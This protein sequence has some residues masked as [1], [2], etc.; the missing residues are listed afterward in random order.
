MAEHVEISYD[1]LTNIKSKFGQLAQNVE[2]MRSKLASQSDSLQGGN[3][4]G[5]GA[6]AFYREMNGEILPAV[7]R[8]H[9][10]LEEAAAVTGEIAEK[11]KAAEEDIKSVWVP[12]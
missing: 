2:R 1:T 10:A 8:L 5:H 11:F 6:D 9:T 3:W 4:K 12:Y 7:D